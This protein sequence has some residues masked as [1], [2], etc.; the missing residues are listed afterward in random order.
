MS[1]A[2]GFEASVSGTLLNTFSDTERSEVLALIRQHQTFHCTTCHGEFNPT[3]N[4]PHWIYVFSPGFGLC[5]ADNSEAQYS[6][7]WALAVGAV[8]E[9]ELDARCKIKAICRDAVRTLWGDPEPEPF[10]D[11]SVAFDHDPDVFSCPAPRC[12]QEHTL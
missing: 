7:S 10:D 3:D 1:D 6:A 4:E 12:D 11:G 2:I 8:E 9:H 5:A